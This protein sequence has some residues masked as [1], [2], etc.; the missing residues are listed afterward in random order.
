MTDDDSYGA[1]SVNSCVDYAA[2]LHY[3]DFIA[4]RTEMNDIEQRLRRLE[5][6]A[7]LEDLV[8]RYFVAADGDDAEG[9]A[10]SFTA[11]GSFSVSGTLCGDT[12]EKIVAFLV[13]E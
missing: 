4:G 6:R 2:T 3:A 9:L 8:L 10:A 5:D 7:E 11:D 13:G 12:R 1:Q